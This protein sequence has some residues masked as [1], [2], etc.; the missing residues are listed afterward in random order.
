MRLFSIADIHGRLD[1]LKKLWNELTTVHNLDLSVDKVIF[2]GDYCDRG[3][4]TYG[5]ICFIKHLVETYPNNVIALAGNHEWINIMYFA[6]KTEDDIW[7]FENNGGPQT[8]ESYRF[9]GYSSMTHEH[10]SWLSKLPFKHEEPGFFFSH[11]PAP[12]DN[13]RNIMNRGLPLT[14]DELCWGVYDP[15][16]RGSSMVHPNGII[17]VCGHIHAIRKGVLAPRFYDHYIFGDSGCGCSSKAPLC[18][19]EV[20]TRQVIYAWPDPV[21]K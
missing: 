11:A 15:D 1:L 20:K 6:R 16:E 2:T 7:L 14:E 5:V 19:I 12:R 17:G 4:E 21:V 9:A 18:A 8:L 3:P 13:R 10:L